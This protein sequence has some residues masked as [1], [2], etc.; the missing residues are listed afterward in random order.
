M[1]AKTAIEWADSTWNPV[2]GCTKVSPGCDNCYAETLAER[3]RGTNGW[4]NGFDVQMRPHK[5]SQPRT[6]KSP[7]RIFVNS[8]SDLFHRA[9]PDDYLVQVWASM[10]AAPQHTYQILTKRPH[11]M[12]YKIKTLGL[13]MHT[14]I[15]LGVS[16]ENQAMADSRLPAL[17]NISAPTRFVSAEPLLG[18]VDMTAWLHLLDWVIVGGESGSK[19]RPMQPDWARSLRDQ[20]VEAGA[21]FFFKQQGARVGH[22]SDKLDGKTWKQFPGEA[23]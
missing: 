18:Q 5:L 8:M 1:G 7:R 2:T 11:R 20:C 22:G 6:W 21:A 10:L 9:I 15:W 17:C 16:V 14:A 23:T 3:Y 12:A 4:P 19:A 13:T